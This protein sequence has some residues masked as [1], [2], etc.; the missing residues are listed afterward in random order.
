MSACLPGAHRLLF[1]QGSAAFPRSFSV[2]A[3]SDSVE[4]RSCGR[5]L[6]VAASQKDLGR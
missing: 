3:F 6:I 1:T 4:F 2:T 5:G